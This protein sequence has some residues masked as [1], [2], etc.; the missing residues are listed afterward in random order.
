MNPRHI[1]SRL[2]PNGLFRAGD[3]RRSMGICSLTSS[4]SS[5]VEIEKR[6]SLLSCAKI[7]QRPCV[8][9]KRKAKSDK[10]KAQSLGPLFHSPLV[11]LQRNRRITQRI[12]MPS[13]CCVAC[14]VVLSWPI[15]FGWQP[16]TSGSSPLHGHLLAQVFQF[17]GGSAKNKRQLGLVCKD[18]RDALN[19]P[20]A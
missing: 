1:R 18:W 9:L 16:A 10:D 17:V 14:L 19:L 5:V 4:R 11:G 12:L 7:G 15:Q 20:L 8:Y 13:M 3:S 2:H 6:P